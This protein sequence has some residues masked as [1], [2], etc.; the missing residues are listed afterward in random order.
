LVRISESFGSDAE[1]KGIDATISI[2]EAELADPSAVLLVIQDLYPPL[3][4]QTLHPL[5]LATH[6]NR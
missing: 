2:V 1:P 6:L 5:A 3:P 4:S